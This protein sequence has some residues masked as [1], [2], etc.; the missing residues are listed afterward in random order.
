[1]IRFADRHDAGRRLTPRLAGFG[2]EEPVVL[3]LPRGGVPVAFEI[4][5]A[6]R[7]PL[8]VLLVRKVGV[9]IQPELAMGAIGEDGVEVVNDLAVREAGVSAGELAQTVRAQRAE[10]DAQSRRL[11]GDRA[12]LAIAGRAVVV[13]DDGIATGSTA[14]VACR[15][16]RARGARRVVVAVPVAPRVSAR[17]LDDADEVVCLEVPSAFGSVGRFYDDFGQVSDAEVTALLARA[18]TATATGTVGPV[19]R[20]GAGA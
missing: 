12:P 7:L 8:D 10:L 11:R 13:V 18:G 19:N 6:L 20:P 9:P 3:A 16:A 15:V 4:A 5:S 17:L 2:D 1:M 14:R